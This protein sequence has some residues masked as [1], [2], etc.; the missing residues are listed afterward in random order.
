MKL[1]GIELLTE[2]SPE[3]Q[4]MALTFDDGKDTAFIIWEYNNMLQ[5]LNDEVI[6]TFR[7]DMLNGK[8]EKFINTIACVAT[9][10]VLEREGRTKLYTNVEDNH[11]NITFSSI[12]EGTTATN[13]V[14]YVV[15][16]TYGSSARATWVDLLV[17]DQ[18]R[19]LGRLRIFSPDNRTIDLKGRYI[20][21]D[22]SRNQYGLSTN[23]VVTIDN[24]F[25]YNPEVEIASHYITQ[26]FAGDESTLSYLTSSKFM[27][28]AKRTVQE[29]PGYIL[30]RLAV[31]LAAEL[32]DILSEVRVDVVK[33]CLLAEKL[34]ILQA[35][36]K[37]K[38]DLVA[39]SIVQ[40][41]SINYKRDT[42]LTLYSEDEAYN[43][44]RFV[45]SQI[46]RMADTLI[47][48]KKGVAKP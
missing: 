48:I 15:D 6:A 31:D 1:T 2:Y 40:G 17:Q 7:K 13:A 25:T 16:S 41:S 26:A 34:Y 14:V 37:L 47:K 44:E 27:E 30:V 32:T 43:N 19:K 10:P 24:R 9:I 3:Q 28:L 8:I 38:Q 18:K 45:L 21:G 35:D 20:L 5:Y 11:C 46:K 4:L 36:S 42:L 33:T 22:I 29:E 23:S 12:E 39:Y